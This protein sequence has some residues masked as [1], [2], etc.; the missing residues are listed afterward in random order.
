MSAAPYT[1][2]T[3]SPNIV[4]ASVAALR[5][6]SSQFNINGSRARIDPAT[7]FTD[8]YWNASSVLAD[9]GVNVIEPTDT[10]GPGR[11]IIEP[12]AVGPIT[13]IGGDLAPV[14]SATQ[15]IVAVQGVP[16]ATSPSPV[17]N[18]V[19]GVEGAIPWNDL[20]D[21]TSDGTLLWLAD[22]GLVSGLAH[23]WSF[24][25]TSKAIVGHAL[26][27]TVSSV[28]RVT[29]ASIAGIGYIFCAVNSSSTD[30]LYVLLASSGA[31]VGIGQFPA[32]GA[33]PS[34]VAYDGSG[35]AWTV[36]I[37]GRVLGFSISA[38]IAAYP[39]PV[40]PFT[41]PLIIAG[42]FD[43]VSD[44][45]DLYVS[46]GTGPSTVVKVSQ[47][48]TP[49]VLATYTDGGGRFM[50]RLY[51]NTAVTGTPSVFCVVAGGS[52]VLRIGTAAMTIV[53]DMPVAGSFGTALS[54]I[55]YHSPYIY[56]MDEFDGYAEL[57]DTTTNLW[58]SE[59]LS[60]VPGVNGLV[61]AAFDTGDSLIWSI[62]T[63]TG[64]LD[65]LTSFTSSS[66]SLNYQGSPSIYYARV[67]SVGGVNLVPGGAT[68]Q[69]VGWEVYASNADNTVRFRFTDGTDYF[70]SGK[71]GTKALGFYAGTANPPL[72]D[73]QFAFDLATGQLHLA[74]LYNAGVVAGRLLDFVTGSPGTYTFNA[75]NAFDLKAFGPLN[76]TFLS[77]DAIR[78]ILE[79]AGTGSVGAYAGGAFVTGFFDI[80]TSI[81]PPATPPVGGY[82]TYSNTNGNLETISHLTGNTTTLVQKPLV[83]S[84]TDATPTAIF[85]FTINTGFDVLIDFIVKARITSGGHAGQTLVLR[86]GAFFENPGGTPAISGTSATIPNSSG[87]YFQLDETGS[88]IPS[89]VSLSF[90]PNTVTI[91]VVGVAATN[92]DWTFNNHPIVQLPE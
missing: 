3:G 40:A 29:F 38:L 42:A 10:P 39:T 36:D 26:P 2:T 18:S 68:P 37:A 74:S 45:T 15:K 35:N 32:S 33:Q 52:H 41:T 7:S 16:I 44:T 12:A 66:S 91:N 84:T 67:P 14:T 19:L 76:N 73:T 89:P 1:N 8:Y 53:Q 31:I 70:E 11:W 80:E 47:V 71:I 28:E 17:A 81:T 58:H 65:Y 34:G 27:A 72:L 82:R 79:F 54:A 51:T 22:G 62:A 77:L 46:T 55:S 9:D 69:V 24:N 13:A 60:N 20:V 30:E 21:L 4:V 83:V 87:I 92:I 88:T 25:P 64:P 49:A 78:S 86:F 59:I 61:G 6:T 75:D 5:A 57:F 50:G 56:A 43:I 90:A 85:S 48:A 23:V 63:V